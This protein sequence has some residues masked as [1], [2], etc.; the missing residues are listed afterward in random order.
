[1]GSEPRE[2]RLLHGTAPCASERLQGGPIH[3]EYI[4]ND[5]ALLACQGQRALMLP[6]QQLPKRRE[7][8]ERKLARHPGLG[9]GSIES[10]RLGLEINASPSQRQHLS[11][12][13]PSEVEHS[14]NRPCVVRQV[15]DDALDLIRRAESLARVVANPNTW[16]RRNAID[17]SGSM[18]NREH[19]S[20]QFH[21][22]E[23]GG[24]SCGFEPA[25][26]ISCYYVVGDIA[27]EHA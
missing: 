9:V 4:W 26:H 8:T 16:K 15:L 7:A 6:T 14:H 3:V 21:F 19:P 23:D 10:D 2:P 24:R 5:A 11:R 17:S 20:Q 25:G 12:P 13:P 22:V 27:G 1:M 18:G